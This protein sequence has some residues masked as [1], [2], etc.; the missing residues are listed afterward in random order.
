METLK[1]NITHDE[2]DFFVKFYF[3]Y[4]NV[5]FEVFLTDF[6]V[7]NKKD[8]ENLINCVEFNKYCDLNFCNS[9]GNVSISTKNNFTTFSVS[10]YGAGGDGAINFKLENNL[11]LDAF[12]QVLAVFQ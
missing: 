11:C 10:K 5:T 4:S 3:T 9:N 8:W 7:I 1:V 12:K 2:D 6:S